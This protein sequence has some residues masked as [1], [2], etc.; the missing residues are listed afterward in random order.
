MAQAQLSTAQHSTLTSST[1][2]APAGAGDPPGWQTPPAAAPPRSRRHGQMAGLR[3]PRCACKKGQL[4]TQSCGRMPAASLL[5]G[6]GRAALHWAATLKTAC[7]CV[8]SQI[9]PQSAPQ[10]A[11]AH[12][13]SSA[14]SRWRPRTGSWDASSNSACSSS[15]VYCLCRAGAW[16]CRL[17][18][19]M[20][21]ASCNA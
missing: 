9:H 14:M 8:F 13:R 10:S 20:L 19:H 17:Q 4:F 12:L 16:V 1:P 18:R 3:A 15:G 2:P 6:S 7:A 11:T 5:F 21:D